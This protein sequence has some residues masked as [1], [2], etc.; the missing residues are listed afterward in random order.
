[1]PSADIRAFVLQ[2]ALDINDK[3]EGAD[4]CAVVAFFSR[5]AFLLPEEMSSQIRLGIAFL[6]RG[7]AN[8]AGLIFPFDINMLSEFCLIIQCPQFLQKCFKEFRLLL[9]NSIDILTKNISVFYSARVVRSL[10]TLPVWLRNNN[11]KT[12]FQTDQIADFLQ[13]DTG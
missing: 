4:I 12:V 9:H 2:L 8:E 3:I 5:F 13:G 6:Q 7:Q 10:R 11:G 1:M